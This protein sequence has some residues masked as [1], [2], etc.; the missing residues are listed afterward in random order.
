MTKNK[1]LKVK[2]PRN[3]AYK[4]LRSPEAK[5]S[6][7]ISKE[8]QQA[9]EKLSAVSSARLVDQIQQ[10]AHSDEQ[11]IDLSRRCRAVGLDWYSDLENHVQ[12]RL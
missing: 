7:C 6:A 9:A 5:K 4:L 10:Y 3:T 2:I 1:Q 12:F 11:Q 8:E